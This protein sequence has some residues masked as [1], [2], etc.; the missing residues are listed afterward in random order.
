MAIISASISPWQ[1]ALTMQRSYPHTVQHPPASS[2]SPLGL[3]KS[4]RDGLANATLAAP[5]LTTAPAGVE[6]EL[7]QP[8]PLALTHIHWTGAAT[9]RGW[10]AR[11]LHQGYRRCRS[12]WHRER[13]FARPA[14]AADFAADDAA[15]GTFQPWGR[16]PKVGRQTFNLLV[17]VRFRAPPLARP[18]RTGSALPRGYSGSAWP[19]STSGLGRHPFKVVARVRIPLGASKT[20]GG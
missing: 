11:P 3:L 18:A 1:L 5:S 2:T 19:P 9:R 13:M 8:V 6:C 16:G 7:T 12:Y 17:S 4:A 10:T 14:D 15:L 20:R